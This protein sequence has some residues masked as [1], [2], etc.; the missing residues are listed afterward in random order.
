MWALPG[1]LV[2]TLS[3]TLRDFAESMAQAA[4][5]Q[6]G[7]RVVDVSSFI[8]EYIGNFEQG[9]AGSHLGQL[10]QLIEEN[11]AADLGAAIEERLGEWEKGSRRRDAQ[12]PGGEDR[13]PRKAYSLGLV[14]PCCTGR[15]GVSTLVWFYKF[16]ACPVARSWTAAWLRQT[17]ALW[18]SD[19][20]D[21][22]RG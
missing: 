11:D 22:G 18:K 16:R 12:E 19:R 9:T 7:G 8:D 10:M 13:R 17:R 1:L 21:Y 5:A 6:S 2:G 3:P 14:L 15:P 4:A 20:T